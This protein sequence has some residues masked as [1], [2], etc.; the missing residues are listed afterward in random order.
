MTWRPLLRRIHLWLG[1][2]LGLPFIVLAATGAALVFYIEIDALLNSS[3]RVHTDLPAPDWDSRV[4]DTALA[5][6]RQTQPGEGVWSFEVTG[7]SG[8]IP[9]R[10]YAHAGRHGETFLLTWFA[11]DGS[12]MLRSARWGDYAMT[13]IYDLHMNLL[14]GDTGNYVVGWLGVVT[15]FLLI[16]GLVV[17]WPRGSW[18]K[19]LAYKVNAVP[20][21]RLYDQHKLIGLASSIFL[22]ILSATGALLGLP[23]EKNWLFSKTIAPVVPV[24]AP[25]STASAG[26]QISISRALSAAHA[27]LPDA[28]LAWFDVPGPGMGVFRIRAQVP[29]D[30][31][32]RFPQSYVFVDQYTGGVLAVHDVR[33][34]TA[35][36][37]VSTWVRPLHDAS[38]GGL[39]T[40]V[41]GVIAGFAP[42]ALFV[43]GLMRWWRRRIDRRKALQVR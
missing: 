28:R 38:I 25:S 11:P 37:T 43:T 4:W 20:T 30:P 41:L 39:S 10:Y 35:S 8:A 9:A 6:A 26:E 40:R 2:V 7:Q 21:R 18:R 5:T 12:H 33:Q 19:A 32:R 42:I 15:L 23:A 1:L 24:P 14:A 13:W 34:G 22:L 16:T 3:I 29:G 31:T 17:W 27:A 36:S